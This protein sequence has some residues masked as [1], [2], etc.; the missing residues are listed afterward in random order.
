VSAL[1]WFVAGVLFVILIEA[2]LLGLVMWRDWEDF[3]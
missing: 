3:E 1:L 2:G